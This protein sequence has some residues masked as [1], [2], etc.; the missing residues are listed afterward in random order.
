MVHSL[1][2]PERFNEI[3]ND[4]FERISNSA[5]GVMEKKD[6]DE[7][8]G[9][10]GNDSFKEEATQ[11]W[12]DRLSKNDSVKTEIELAI[13]LKIRVKEKLKNTKLS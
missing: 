1:E 9:I 8:L 10:L 6:Q 4:V 7:A 5:L 11:S 2:N 12:G 13:G 3:P